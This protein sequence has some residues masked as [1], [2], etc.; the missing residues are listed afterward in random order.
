MELGELCVVTSSTK[1][2]QES[3]AICSVTG[4]YIVLDDVTWP[5]KLK[6]VTPIN[7]A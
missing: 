6:V 7:Y 3:S 4:M 2:Q 1:Q 5:L